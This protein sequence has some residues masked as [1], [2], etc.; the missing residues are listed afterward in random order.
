MANPTYLIAT[1]TDVVV[2]VVFND[3]IVIVDEGGNSL[4]YDL[5]DD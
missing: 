2:A 4:T 3:K 1:M 5:K